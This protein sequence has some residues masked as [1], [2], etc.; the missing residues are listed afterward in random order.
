[1]FDSLPIEAI[2]AF[3][4]GIAASLAVVLHKARKLYAEGQELHQRAVALKDCYTRAM[5]DGELQR[6]EFVELGN[7]VGVLVS[8]LDAFQRKLKKAF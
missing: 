3:G 1:M 2:A 5:R 4:I 7:R 6:E 8:H